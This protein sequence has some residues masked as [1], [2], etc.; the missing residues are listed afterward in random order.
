MVARNLGPPL[1]DHPAKKWVLPV[2]TTLKTVCMASM[3][4]YIAAGWPGSNP[5][6]PN[7]CN[8]SRPKCHLTS[9]ADWWPLAPLDANPTRPLRM[10]KSWQVEEILKATRED[11]LEMIRDTVSFL[12]SK[13]RLIFV[14][15][16]H[17]FDSFCVE[18]SMEAVCGSSNVCHRSRLSA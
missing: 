2:R 6:M 9:G 17:I 5:N 11:N 4:D 13:G 3:C 15:L 14:D 18:S 1:Q 7:S 10:H 16:G 12:C 8:V